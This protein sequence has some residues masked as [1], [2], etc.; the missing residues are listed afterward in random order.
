MVHGQPALAAPLHSLASTATITPHQ[1]HIKQGLTVNAPDIKLSDYHHNLP[2][3]SPLANIINDTLLAIDYSQIIEAN[4]TIRSSIPMQSGLGS[5]ASI[6]TA[7]AKALLAYLGYSLT[8]D[9]LAN[10]VYKTE[11]LQHGN[12]SGIDNIVIAHATPILYSKSSSVKYLT[13][14]QPLHYVLAHS[15]KQ[16]DTRDTVHLFDMQRKSNPQFHS[17]IK[18]IGRLS[19][20]GAAAFE[21]GDPDHLGKLM[22]INHKLLQQLCVSTNRLDS[23]VTTAIEAGAAGAKLSGAGHG[24]HIVAQVTN[25]S[26]ASVVNALKAIGADPFTTFITPQS[27]ED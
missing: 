14:A 9:E 23:L 17:I 12:P 2:T 21:T 11:A 8:K 27:Y 4:I 26:S 18:N 19:L 7:I 10:L 22:T 16:S 20:K 1:T 5:S 25:N 6:S 15:G 3:N 24:G 13:P